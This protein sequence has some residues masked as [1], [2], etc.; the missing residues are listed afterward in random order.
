MSDLI[1]QANS[2]SK[3]Y[4]LGTIGSNSLRRDIHA[5]WQNRFNK[6]NTQPLSMEQQIRKDELWALKD[7]NFEVK[8]GDAWGIIGRNGAGKSTFLKILS[9]ITKPTEGTIKGRGKISSLLEIGTGFHPDLT[10][11]ENIFICQFYCGRF[12]RGVMDRSR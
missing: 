6:S 3:R 12:Y 5:W 8:E 7:V 11:R 1:I 9:R 2:I 10:G 4:Q